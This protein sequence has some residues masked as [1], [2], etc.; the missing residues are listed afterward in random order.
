[1]IDL[2]WGEAAPPTAPT[3]LGFSALQGRFSGRVQGWL[4]H[5][6]DWRSS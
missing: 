6:A 4:V 1:L 2:V 3:V 5:P